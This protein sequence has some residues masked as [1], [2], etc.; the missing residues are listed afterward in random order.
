[1]FSLCRCEVG[2]EGAHSRGRAGAMLREWLV[3]IN[4]WGV[5]LS[6]R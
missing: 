5:Y 1:M 4:Y 2:L 3:S 6:L